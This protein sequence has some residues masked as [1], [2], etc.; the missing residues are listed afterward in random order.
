MNIYLLTNQDIT[1]VPFPDTDWPCDPRPFLPKARWHVEVLLDKKQGPIRTKELIDEDRF[2]LFF[3]LCDGAEGQD[4]LPGIEVVQVLEAHGVPF[5]G[6]GS[7][8]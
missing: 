1:E 3:N 6:A 8:F 4:D 5:T 2:D 7:S